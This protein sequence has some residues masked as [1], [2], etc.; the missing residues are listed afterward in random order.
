MLWYQELNFH[1]EGSML[2][3]G[4]ILQSCTL[5]QLWDELKTSCDF[6][7]ARANV[8]HFNLH[9]RWRKRGV[10]MVPTKFGISFTTKHMNQ[11]T[12]L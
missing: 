11:V 2:H 10:A 6:V 12:D 9:N 5:T 3:Y 1:N 8:N 4:M 7:K